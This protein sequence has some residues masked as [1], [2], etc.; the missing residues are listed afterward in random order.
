MVHSD[1]LPME[2][3]L[4][5]MKWYK[6]GLNY[7]RYLANRANV[8][9]SLNFPEQVAAGVDLYTSPFHGWIFGYLDNQ[10]VFDSRTYFRKDYYRVENNDGV[11]YCPYNPHHNNPHLPRFV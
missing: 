8:Q 5:I 1:N 2:L 3:V 11:K 10:L 9:Y 6:Q 4:L 7:R